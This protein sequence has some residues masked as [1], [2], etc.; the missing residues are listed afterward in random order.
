MERS[1]DIYY[2]ECISD[3]PLW[4]VG[5]ILALTGIWLGLTL[6]RREM[7]RDAGQPIFEERS[8]VGYLA[9]EVLNLSWI[10]RETAE[11]G[12]GHGT[13]IAE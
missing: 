12:T 11:A 9:I 13:R 10:A 8:D 7:T 2:Q 4:Y 1:A 5:F 6:Y 3:D